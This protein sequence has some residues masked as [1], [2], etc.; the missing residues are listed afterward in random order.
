MKIN[1]IT[2]PSV[3]FELL[4]KLPPKPGVYFALTEDDR[5]LYVGRSEDIRRRWTSRHHRHAQIARYNEVNQVRVAY[6][7]ADKFI[8]EALEAQLIEQLRPE[9]NGRRLPKE[10]ILGESLEFEIIKLRLPID[11]WDSINSWGE[12]HHGLVW[13][14]LPKATKID[15]LIGLGLQT[16]GLS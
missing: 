10:E 5:L 14:H 9:L 16:Q 13:C 11:R 2:L 8:L 7:L 15:I 1:P 4:E 3:E 6:Y 12:E